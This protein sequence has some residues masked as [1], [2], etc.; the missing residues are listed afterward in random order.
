M[1]EDNRMVRARA[2]V[3]LMTEVA[4]TLVGD[5]KGVHLR[6]INKDDS[7]ANSLRAQ[8]VEQRM[9]FAPEGWTEIGT[10][11]KKKILQPMVY[12]V[13]NTDVLQRPVLV[14]TITDGVPS[15]ENSNEFRKAIVESK[16]ELKAKN[17]Q[18][19]GMCLIPLGYYY[20]LTHVAVLFDLSQVGNDPEAVAFIESFDGDSATSDVLHRTAGMY[21]SW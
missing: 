12:D 6:F 15:K 10:N 8:G 7:T 20:V 13:I 9:N 16:K 14:L 21:S 5:N 2:L 18:K 3:T 19:Q 17:Y 11:L 4:T 1:A